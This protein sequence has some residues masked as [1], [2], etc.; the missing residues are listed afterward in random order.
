[1]RVRSTLTG[2]AAGT[3]TRHMARWLRG[4]GV[5]MLAAAVVCSTPA[6]CLC[7][8]ARGASPHKHHCCAAARP[9]VCASTSCCGAELTHSDATVTDALQ[10]EAPAA[11]IVSIHADAHGLSSEYVPVQLL[12]PSPPHPILRI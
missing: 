5:M 1:M 8:N 7:H 2:T 12:G 4:V 3:Q 6:V 9:G 11:A 10:L